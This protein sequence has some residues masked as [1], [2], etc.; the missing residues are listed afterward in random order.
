GAAVAAGMCLLSAACGGSRPSVSAPSPQ[1]ATPS[2]AT[3]PRL[4]PT[5]KPRT[6]SPN[7]L[8]AE[9]NS[10]TP[11]DIP[12]NPV[13]ITFRDPAGRY[14][15]KYPEGWAQQGAGAKV[16]F[17]DKNNIVRVLVTSGAP[18][19]K[20]LVRREVGQLAGATLR[21]SPRLVT[22]GGAPVIALVY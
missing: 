12:D 4:N 8:Q 2:T 13:F 7:P 10:P 5:P 3:T 19:T 16:T 17:R 20:G 11:R 14:S 9:A 21:S 1:T 6:P 18:P 22:I 15:L